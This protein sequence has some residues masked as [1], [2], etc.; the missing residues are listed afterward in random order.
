MVLLASPP[1]C[2]WCCFPP[3]WVVVFSSSSSGKQHHPKRRGSG[4]TYEKIMTSTSTT[5]NCCTVNVDD[6][7]HIQTRDGY[8]VSNCRIHPFTSSTVCNSFKHVLDSV[9]LEFM[10]VPAVGGYCFQR[11]PSGISCTDGDDPHQFRKIVFVSDKFQLVG[12]LS[13]FKRPSC[14]ACSS[15]KKRTSTCQVFSNP[16][17]ADMPLA[18][19][20]HMFSLHSFSIALIPGALAENLSN[21]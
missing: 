12:A 10:C 2:G 8:H 13:T 18:A 3:F 19:L 14:T 17:E 5:S 16:C 1:P 11:F 4:T 9:V 7:P 15:H 21:A 20:F 6:S